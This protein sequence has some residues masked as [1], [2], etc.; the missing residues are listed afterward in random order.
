MS[1]PWGSLLMILNPL[2]MGEGPRQWQGAHGWH[3]PLGTRDQGAHTYPSPLLPAGCP[4]LAERAFISPQSLSPPQPTSLHWGQRRRAQ[5]GSSWLELALFCRRTVIS[6]AKF[7]TPSQNT[8]ML[9]EALYS[10][11]Q[12]TH[13]C[14]LTVG[15]A[16]TGTERTG[17]LLSPSPC[18]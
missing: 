4:G 9:G 3:S 2:G 5:P 11:R 8:A 12:T 16:P 1:L 10:Q 17:S 18:D 15:I 13:I 14:F 7:P 6:R